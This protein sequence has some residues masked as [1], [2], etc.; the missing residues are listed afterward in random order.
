MEPKF[1]KTR[2]FSDIVI[3]I[4]L[5]VLGVLLVLV[6]QS[7]SV[8]I[9]G[10]MVACLGIVLFFAMKHAWKDLVTGDVYQGKVLYYNKAKKIAILNAVNGDI[11]ALTNIKEEESA[12]KSL[13]LDVFYSDKS[14]KV[15]CQLFE[16]VPYEFRA[17]S[18]LCTFPLDELRAAM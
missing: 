9:A 2:T 16:Y 15:Y 14:N 10:A 18:T 12:N 17:V 8:S 6:R 1:V 3:S 13:R 7:S 4:S 5:T 11:I